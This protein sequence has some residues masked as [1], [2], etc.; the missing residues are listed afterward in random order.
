MP[1]DLCALILDKENLTE[2]DLYR[3]DGPVN[4]HRMAAV[5]DEDL[6]D[7]PSAIQVFRN[8]LANDPEDRTAIDAL[9][10]LYERT[11]AWADLL[12]IIDAVNNELGDE[13]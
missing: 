6:E 7:L 4:L 11:E 12:D 1:G 9:D 13:E 5:Y 8:L 2:E 10:R 3:V